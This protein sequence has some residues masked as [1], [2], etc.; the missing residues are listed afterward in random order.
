MTLPNYTMND[1]IQQL[2]IQYLK[3]RIA[4][5]EVE[6]DYLKEN[7]GMLVEETFSLESMLDAIGAGGVG[8]SIQPQ[9]QPD[10]AP[11]AW[12]IFTR[13]GFCRM[14]SQDRALVE[15]TAAE[16]GVKAEPLYRCTG[17]TRQALKQG[18]QVAPY[19]GDVPRIMREAG[20]TFHLGLPHKAVVEQMTRVVDLVYAEASIKAAVAFAAPQPAAQPDT[21]P[22]AWA[23][24]SKDGTA[25]VMWSRDMPSA[26]NTAEKLGLPLVP[27][28]TAPQPTE[29]LRCK[30]TQKRLAMLWG[31]VKQEPARQPLP[32]DTYTALA[33]RIATRFTYSTDRSFCEYYFAIHTLEQFVRAIEQAHGIT[34]GQ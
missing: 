26:K 20:M 3:T 32:A 13:A 29:N 25:M 5:L 27:L 23:I 10:T 33:H 21:A 15:R 11:A 34:G 1:Q 30:S 4:Q 9:A 22:A 16:L 31:Y 12:A 18:E 6:R 24:F 28:Y 17:R 19:T 2:E 8:A 14:W 7:V